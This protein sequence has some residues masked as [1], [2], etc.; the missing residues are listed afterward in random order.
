MYQP[1][2]SQLAQV[3]KDWQTIWKLRETDFISHFL[4]SK[5][6]NLLA[7]VIEGK[8]LYVISLITKKNIFEMT[9]VKFELYDLQF[10]SDEKKICIAQEESKSLRIIELSTRS[11][12]CYKLP[13]IFLPL[14][15]YIL[16]EQ[17]KKIYLY[18]N[19]AL[20]LID[21]NQENLELLL[22]FDGEYRVLQKAS[23]D[24]IINIAFNNELQVMYLKNNFCKQKYKYVES[25]KIIHFTESNKLLSVITFDNNYKLLLKNLQSKKLIRKLSDNVLQNICDLKYSKNIKYLFLN[26]GNCLIRWNI[27]TSKLSKLLVQNNVFEKIWIE[28]KNE[29]FIL[30]SNNHIQKASCDF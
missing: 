22:Q 8:K 3:S 13:S 4:V 23:L 24:F 25:N 21:L 10:T 26:T 19:D 16:V 1:K 9:F 6:G 30:N 17:E 28:G 7:F 2:K 14:D 20:N 27:T 12:I 11:E 15:S 29:I 18:Q 5:S